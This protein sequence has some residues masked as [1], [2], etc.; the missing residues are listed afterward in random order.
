[1]SVFQNILFPV[2]FSGK[3]AQ[4]ARS[5]AAIARQ[6]NSKV[7]M[8]HAIGDYRGLYTPDAPTPDE[9]IAWMHN[10]STGRLQSFGSPCLDD[11]V[12][13]RLVK[14]GEP[15]DVIA[16]YASRGGIDS[17]MMPTHGIGIFRRYL[18]GSV[19]ARVLHDCARP[20]WT[21]VH[22]PAPGAERERIRNIVCATDL[23]EPSGHVVKIAAGIARD[24]GASLHLVHAIPMPVTLGAG[25]MESC[26]PEMI[27]EIQDTARARLE[28]VQKEVGVAV[29]SHAQPGFVLPVVSAAI[30]RHHADLLVIGRGHLRERFGALHSDISGLVRESPCPV[31]S[32]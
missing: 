25:G 23:T 16:A 4:T 13:A 8:L 17:I 7:T 2:D 18:L 32:V 14:D 24:C 26:T 10:T 15:A 20:I 19:T 30:T 29:D 31:L 6:F 27:E 3:C 22:Q 21:T 12:V 1:M 5:V 11:F 9:W 28:E